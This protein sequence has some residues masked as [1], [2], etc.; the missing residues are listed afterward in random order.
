M[1]SGQPSTDSPA[2]AAWLNRIEQIH[3]V[4]WDLGL[5]RVAEVGRKLDV[6]K[7][8]TQ[9]ILVA[10]TNGKGSTCE[11]LA[12]LAE[13]AGLNVGK[14][15]SPHLFR[16]NERIEINGRP[17]ADDLIVESFERIEAARSEIT[18]TYFEFATLASLDLFADADLDVAI[19]EIGLGGRLDAMNIVEPDLC[20]ITS[21]SM[22]HEAWLGNTREAIGL[23]KAGIMRPGVPCV[24]T[25]TDPPTSILEHAAETDTPLLRLGVDFDLQ[26]AERFSPQMPAP[27][28]AGALQA[29]A[30]LH[31][32]VP[33]D[34]V[35]R[36]ATEATLPGRGST[37]LLDN[38]VRVILDVAH[39]PAAASYLDSQL[40]SR[41]SG[42]GRLHAVFG[43]FKDKDIA[44]V[45]GPLQDR[46]DTW[47]IAALDD[48]RG[49]SVAQMEDALRSVGAGKSTAYAKLSEALNGALTQAAPGDTVL[50]FG[51]FL[52]VAEAMVHLDSADP[53][54]EH[55][56]QT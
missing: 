43:I 6:L 52:V 37:R 17:V 44:G 16:F 27:S 47:H 14:S 45:V 35:E 19:L 53:G 4:G 12:R 5:D 33:A 26:A 21:I 28:L 39:N 11:Y 20:I 40:G 9:V 13:A 25:D 23:E 8:A 1:S 22:D 50:A 3:P 56:Q 49:A 55:T 34:L 2:L 30:Q 51:S 41:L 46:I 42:S 54:P 18:L 31:W 32:Q 38:N 29:A 10:G 48:P 36:V 7:P 15:T 24:V